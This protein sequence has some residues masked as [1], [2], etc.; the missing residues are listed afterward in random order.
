MSAYDLR[1]WWARQ[2]QIIAYNIVFTELIFHQKIK[3]TNQDT[4]F[5]C[6]FFDQ[7]N[8]FPLLNSPTPLTEL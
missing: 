8:H 1:V 3:D 6:C 7:L 5:K 4:K 2:T